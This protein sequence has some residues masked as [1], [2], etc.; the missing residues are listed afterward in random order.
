MWLFLFSF[1]VFILSSHPLS[2]FD[3]VSFSPFVIVCIFS[4]SCLT[5]KPMFGSPEMLALCCIYKSMFL[6]CWNEQFQ[7]FRNSWRCQIEAEIHLLY[8]F[9]LVFKDSFPCSPSQKISFLSPWPI[10]QILLLRTPYLLLLLFLVDAIEEFL[11]GHD[12][13]WMYQEIKINPLPHH[14]C[15]SCLVKS[16]AVLWQENCS[17]KKTAGFVWQLNV[18]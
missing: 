16:I 10:F 17:L 15:C 1:L 2:T 18:T 14:F 4:W 9:W 13:C 12:N 7:L 3:L 5:N 8:R 11:T 6:L